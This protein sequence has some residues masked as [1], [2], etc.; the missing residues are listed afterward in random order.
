MG[1]PIAAGMPY[2]VGEAG[3]E[4]IRAPAGGGTVIPN[5]QIG[6]G[7]STNINF[8]INAVDATG[9][10]ELLYDRREVIKG[11]ISD[12]MLEKGQRF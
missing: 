10:D 12:A 6:M 7:G 8:T 11:I 5:D 9:V 1:G 3:P 2:L 4:I